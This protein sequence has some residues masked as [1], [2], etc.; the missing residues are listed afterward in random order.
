MT[1]ASTS[2]WTSVWTSD[3][4]QTRVYVQGVCAGGRGAVCACLSA[5]SPQR[6]WSAARRPRAELRSRCRQAGRQE[7]KRICVRTY[8]WVFIWRH[9]WRG[10]C[11]LAYIDACMYI[12]V[13]YT[14][15]HTD[16]YL[17]MLA[18]LLLYTH[19]CMHNIGQTHRS[20]DI[21]TD[22]RARVTICIHV[23]MRTH[24]GT[25]LDGPW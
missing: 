2:A 8:E 11:K 7:G 1:S 15:M 4:T 6:P 19:A 20:I 9:G 24:V 25:Y 16:R 18:T 5:A 22:M 10:I 12:Y 14:C 3:P 17:Y 21:Y 13:K 23:C